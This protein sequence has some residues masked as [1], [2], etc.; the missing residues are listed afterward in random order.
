MS[1]YC[2]S[3]ATYTPKCPTCQSPNIKKIAI[4]EKAE[5]VFLFGMLFGKARKQW[6]CNNCGNEW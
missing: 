3:S 1:K 2:P 6:H 5:S 4:L